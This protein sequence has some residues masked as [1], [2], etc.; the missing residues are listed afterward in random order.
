M[1][2]AQADRRRWNSTTILCD[3][4][5]QAERLD[6]LL[7]DDRV[8]RRAS[9]LASSTAASSFLRAEPRSPAYRVLTDHE[10]FRRERRFVVP[11][12]TPPELRSRV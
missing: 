12:D 7:N 10:I 8:S 4:A 5:G 3:N 9:L 2:R 1:K 11:A 6:E